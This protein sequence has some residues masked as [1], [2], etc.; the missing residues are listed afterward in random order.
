M[1]EFEF[2]P[3]NEKT[4]LDLVLGWLV[5]TKQTTGM[6]VDI[7]RE[8]KA[9]FEFVRSIQSRNPSYSSILICN[10]EPVGYLCTFPMSKHPES[11]WLDF[12]YL[13]PK[14]RGTS[15]SSEIVRR[16]VEIASESGCLNISLNV[17][18]NNTRGIAFYA[19][20]GWRL[21]REGPDGMNR[22]KKT[23]TFG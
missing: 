13:V 7:G 15:A 23:L 16:I 17:H 11:S 2:R 1:A 22:M 3:F 5:E 8:R 4:D 9:Y 6:P 20:N 14:E 18:M 21:E 19:K 10:E 12:C